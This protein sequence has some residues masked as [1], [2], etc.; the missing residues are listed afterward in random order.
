MNYYVLF[1]FASVVTAV[2]AAVYN[3]V[4]ANFDLPMLKKTAENVLSGK[5]APNRTPFLTFKKFS[6]IYRSELFTDFKIYHANA[7]NKFLGVSCA[8]NHVPYALT[9]H[10]FSEIYVCLPVPPVLEPIYTAYE[11]VPRERNF[12]IPCGMTGEKS[13]FAN[14]E[15]MN[16]KDYLV[17]QDPKGKFH[18]SSKYCVGHMYQIG[19]NNKEI[20]TVN[21]TVTDYSVT[22]D[23]PSSYCNV[24][25]LPIK[26]LDFTLLP[27]VVRVKSTLDVIDCLRVERSS[28]VVAGRPMYELAIDDVTLLRY[29]TTTNGTHNFAYTYKSR[30]SYPTKTFHISAAANVNPFTWVTTGL[31]TLLTPI[32]DFLLNSF[33]YCFESLLNIFESTPFLNLFD[34][35]LHFIYNIISLI[36]K[37]IATHIFPKI[38]TFIKNIPIRY[39]FLLV[40]LFVMYLKTTKFIFSCCVTA[41]IHLCIK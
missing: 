26:F 11:L 41:L 3:D 19:L 7:W 32:L 37:F 39:K 36:S 23:Y 21:Y 1:F 20:L 38:L 35:L 5:Y 4:Y 13:T 33:L 17:L 22:I 14:F 10:I 16:Y 9:H 6:T 2:S 30:H 40:F 25:P 28:N 15:P 27:I 12:F 29:N 8:G 31:L 24:F 18:L 34:R